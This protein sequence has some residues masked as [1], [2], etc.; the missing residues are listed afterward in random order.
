MRSKNAFQVM[1]ETELETRKLAQMPPYNR[2][3]LWTLSHRDQKL[4]EAE[5]QKLLKRMKIFAAHLHVEVWGPTPAPVSRWKG[6]WRLQILSR[7][8]PKGQLTSF[9]TAVLDEI[10]RLSLKSKLKLDRDP[11]HFL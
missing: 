8:D 4:V 9:Q 1:A 11:Y 3:A 10:E 6:Q 7:A 5:S 2:L